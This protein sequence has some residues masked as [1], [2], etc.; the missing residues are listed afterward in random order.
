M[1][2]YIQNYNILQ[3]P[4]KF[5]KKYIIPTQNIR[6]FDNFEKFDGNLQYYSFQYIYIYLYEYS[7]SRMNFESNFLLLGLLFAI[8]IDLLNGNN[9]EIQENILSLFSTLTND[10][11]FCQT[12]AT[13][14]EFEII[15]KVY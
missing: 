7:F 9:I 10:P 11:S 15:V 13:S 12:M 4:T 1:I 8:A 2:I 3:V 6:N 5:F 14:N